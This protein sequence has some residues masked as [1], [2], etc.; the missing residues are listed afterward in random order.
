MKIRKEV[1]QKLDNNRGYGLIMMALNCS[2]S[3]ARVYIKN[4]SDDLTK[5][6]ALKAIGEELKLTQEEILE[7]ELE[8][9]TK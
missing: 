3:S 1:L 9:T 7:A 5:A 2:F 4:N 6:V 8:G